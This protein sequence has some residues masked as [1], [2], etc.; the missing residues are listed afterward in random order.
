MP[1]WGQFVNR[2]GEVRENMAYEFRD[3]LRQQSRLQ[4]LDNCFPFQV[5]S[6]EAPVVEFYNFY[7]V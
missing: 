7:G 6:L 4:D 5:L 2:F 1:L 3:R